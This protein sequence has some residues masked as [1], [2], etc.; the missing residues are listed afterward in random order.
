LAIQSALTGPKNVSKLPKKNAAGESFSN[1][2]SGSGKSKS[3]SKTSKKGSANENGSSTET[4]LSAKELDGVD[5]HSNLPKGSGGGPD[6]ERCDKWK[7]DSLRRRLW[8]RV[9]A[10]QC[11]RRGGSHLRSACAKPVAMWEEDFNKGPS[12]WDPPTQRVQWVVHRESST[13]AIVVSSGLT[14]CPTS[15]PDFAL[16]S[17]TCAPSHR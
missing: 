13:L 16:L 14:R 15:P 5:K 1:E 10:K 17:S 2:K 4:F 6:Q 7:K 8:D 3:D 9:K 12:F 11:V